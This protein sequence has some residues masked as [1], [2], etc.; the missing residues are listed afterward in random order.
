V[1]AEPDHDRSK[2]DQVA[3]QSSQDRR[4]RAAQIQAQQRAAER[5][6]SLLIIGASVLV[7]VVIVGVVIYGLAGSEGDSESAEDAAGRTNSAIDGV[8]DFSGLSRDHVEGAVDYP[9][10]P[11][12]GGD[13]A[14]VWVNCGT[15]SE[16]VSAEM[17]VHSL[18]H[19]AVW[20]AYQ[21]GLP[22]N[23]VEDLNA[24]AENNDYVLVS[25]VEGMDAP[26]VA[27]AWGEQ[28]ALEQADDERLAAFVTAYANGPQ[29][30]EPGAPCTGG[31]SGMG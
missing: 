27:T 21:P 31:V 13:H 2:E 19:G 7:A 22:S 25:P 4:G 30:P 16:P 15:Y 11:P 10:N 18:E 17:A 12:V 1:P 26:V 24:L 8:K 20:V 9:Q 23:D 3:K 28:L 6:R 29:T 5:R 14:P